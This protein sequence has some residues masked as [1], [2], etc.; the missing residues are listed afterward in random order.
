MELRKGAG[1]G[2]SFFQQLI[3]L[4]TTGSFILAPLLTIS[5]GFEDTP[6][7]NL[8]KFVLCQKSLHFAY[9]LVY[10]DSRKDHTDRC[11]HEQ[12]AGEADGGDGGDV[13]AHPLLR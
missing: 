9:H 3:A 7:G 5:N 8:S 2:E 12:G 11:F 10:Y 13:H 4:G 1:V 6:V